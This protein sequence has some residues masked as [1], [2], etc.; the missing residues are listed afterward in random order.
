MTLKR[1]KR[2]DETGAEIWRYH[3]NGE[4]MYIFRFSLQEGN[5]RVARAKGEYLYTTPNFH[6]ALDVAEDLLRSYVTN[7]L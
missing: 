1:R 4:S 6:K 2:D 7:S 3:Y 5:W